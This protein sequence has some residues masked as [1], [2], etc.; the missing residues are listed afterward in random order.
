M[1]CY[2]A[3]LNTPA[4]I[5]LNAFMKYSAGIDEFMYWYLDD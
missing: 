3:I 4:T 1:L 5:Y 2:S